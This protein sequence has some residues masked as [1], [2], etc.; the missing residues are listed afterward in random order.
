[1]DGGTPKGVIKGGSGPNWSGL[2]GSAAGIYPDMDGFA[3][4][5]ALDRRFNPEM[6][7]DRR[8]VK[9]ARWKRAVSATLSV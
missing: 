3:A 2:A 1:M 7:A 4:S 8:A 6:E 5:W 9:Y